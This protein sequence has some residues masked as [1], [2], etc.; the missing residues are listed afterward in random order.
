[1]NKSTNVP[2]L[3]YYPNIIPKIT[4][5]K[6]LKYFQ[7]HPEEE[8]PVMSANSRRVR[9]YGYIYDYTNRG[10]EEK[11][12]S[13]PDVMAELLTLIPSNPCDFNQCIVNHYRPGEGISAHIDS[14]KFGPV[15]A[16][17]TINGGIEIEF[18]RNEKVEKLYVEDNSLYI[19]SGEAR[20]RWTHSISPR[21][22]D[23]VNGTRIRRVLR[24]SLTFRHV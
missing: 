17:F 9:Q 24:H 1:M 5:E 23:T 22:Y 7:E 18:R 15:I 21:L 12:E 20:S 10:V 16:C 4:K 19:M 6:I 2:G 8:K 14:P 3:S 11:A 13:I